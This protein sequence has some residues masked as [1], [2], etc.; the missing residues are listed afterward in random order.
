MPN[1]MSSVDWMLTPCGC[2]IR[3]VAWHGRVL[4]AAADNGRKPCGSP[5]LKSPTKLQKQTAR[6]LGFSIVTRIECHPACS[7]LHLSFCGPSRRIG[8]IDVLRTLSRTT[9]AG[10]DHVKEKTV[11]FADCRSGSLGSHFRIGLS[12]SGSKGGSVYSDRACGGCCRGGHRFAVKSLAFGPDG[13]RLISGSVDRTVK[14]WDLTAGQELLS[15]KLD[16]RVWSVAFSPDGKRLASASLDD[17]VRLWDATSGQPL[18]TLTGHT[19]YVLSIAFSP[20]GKRLVSGSIDK[21]VKVWDVATGQNL[22]TRKG[23]TDRVL[24]VAFGPDGKRLASGSLDK[25]VKVW[26]ASDKP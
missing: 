2:N 20:D 13:K 23:H 6:K 8:L 12:G 19:E 10:N 5:I 24:G 4:Y 15:W 7:G 11:D 14:V 1:R 18:L 17:N 21:T 3:L 16:T 22:L 9:V 26:D 25:T